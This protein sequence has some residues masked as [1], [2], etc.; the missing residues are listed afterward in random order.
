VDLY[1]PNSL[2]DYTAIKIHQARDFWRGFTTTGMHRTGF[3][4]LLLEGYSQLF[5][6][7]KG[8]AQQARV[9]ALEGAP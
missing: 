2:V 4:S 9:D 3:G 1:N 8:E 7:P 5:W 6:M